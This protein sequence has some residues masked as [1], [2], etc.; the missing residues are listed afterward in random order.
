MM[1]ILYENY[2]EKKRDAK[3]QAESGGKRILAHFS[4][5]E[6]DMTLYELFD[7]GELDDDLNSENPIGE[8]DE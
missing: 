4:I 8:E 6:D 1:D 3:M 5:K 7:D 2:L